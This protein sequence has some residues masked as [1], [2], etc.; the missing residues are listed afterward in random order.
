MNPP[1]AE[2]IDPSLAAAEG[3]LARLGVQ[4]DA[5][6]AVLVRLLQDVVDAETRL[7]D[8]HAAQLVEV[9]EQ[10]VLAALASQA[11]AEAAAQALTEA[12]QAS[13]LDALTRLPNRTMLLDRFVQAV[14]QCKRQG[15]HLALLFLD[16]DGFKQLND[17]LGHAFG[18]QVL[19]RVAR[20]LVAAVREVDTVSRHGGDEFLILL[21][22]LTQP[23]DAQAVAEKLIA[24]I[25]APAEGGGPAVALTASVGIAVYPDDGV[26]VD[27]LVARADAAMY[28]TKRQRAG[29]IA[30]HGT[31]LIEAPARPGLPVPERGAQHA[32]ARA[33]PRAGDATDTEHRL[34][35][36][37]EANEKL[38]LAAL[39][40]QELQA[41]AELAQQRQAAFLAAVADEL[42]NPMAPIRI[43]AEM[44]GRR[45]DEVPL[46]PRVQQLV[47]QQITRMSRLVDCLVEASDAAP[48]GLELD[49]RWVD[50]AK[51]IDAAVAAYR[52][53]LDRHGQRFESSRPA[54]ALGV[55]G[56]AARLEQV[57]ANLL[58]NACTHTPDGGRI[59]L[60]VVVDADRLTLTVS[61]DGIGISPQL[62]PYVFEPFVLD[63]LALD[64]SGVGLGIGLTVVRAL[65]RAHGGDIAAHSAGTRRGSQFVVTLPLAP[66]PASPD[67]PAAAVSATGVA[68]PR[69]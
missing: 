59:R 25:G 38:V 44:L 18:D 17:T 55:L 20:R 41:A 31:G 26:D 6:Q 62:L 27:T 22:D 9:N 36:L 67:V 57:V 10:L 35:H 47:E 5:M 7:Q 30:F 34:A 29:G 8:T 15:T 60:A 63:A 14:A 54:G 58:D 19:Q 51:V 40:A 11:E 2:P 61:D 13:G 16:L 48:D 43:A 32:D 42:S 49:H 4:V 52:P 53:R 45:P 12:A 69:R 1:P 28:Q 21:A 66:A 56:D 65:V 39:S 3:K 68:N 33:G 50:L 64:F 24:A 46:L 23:G 37:R